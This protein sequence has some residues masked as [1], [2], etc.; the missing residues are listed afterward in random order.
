MP[1]ELVDQRADVARYLEPQRVRAG[2]RDRDPR[3]RTRCGAGPANVTSIVC[4]LRCRSSA[5]VPWSTRRPARRIPTRSHVA[6]TSL[7]MCDERNTVCPRSLASCD[8]LPEG[9]L[10]QRVEPAGRLVEQQQVRAGGERGDQLH[11][12]AVA[13]RQRSHLLA[14]LQ[15][16]ALDELRR[17]S[18]TSIAAVQAA[19]GTRASRRPSSRA[20]RTAPR[21]RRRPAGARGPDRPRRRRRTA[22]PRPPMGGAARAAAGSWSSCR[23]RSARDSR[24]P[25]RAGWSG[26]ARR[27]RASARIA[28]SALRLRSR[29][30]AWTRD[31]PCRRR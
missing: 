4:A 20:T 8:R 21:R 2:A 10:H 11:L 13:L 9:H 7:R 19:R 17:G 22:R 12:L 31:C 28:W 5:S 23:R 27:A 18:A 26:R 14:R 6:S 15:L 16:E 1:G 25:P 24:T 3:E 29:K 30:R